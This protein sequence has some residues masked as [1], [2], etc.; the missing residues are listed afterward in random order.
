MAETKHNESV[1]E[2]FVANHVLPSVAVEESEDTH[3]I[4]GL[5]DSP[6]IQVTILCGIQVW[7]YLDRHYLLQI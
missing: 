6:P 5:T 1:D 4:Y 2:E 3:L 7:F